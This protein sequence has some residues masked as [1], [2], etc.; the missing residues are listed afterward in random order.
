[1]SINIE[2]EIVDHMV[3]KVWV[4]KLKFSSDDEV[5]LEAT[6][7]ILLV[8]ANNSGKS[9]TI[10][11]IVSKSQGG[12]EY[13]DLVV[14]K[15]LVIEKKGTAQDLESYVKR[16]GQSVDSNFVVGDWQISRY[17]FQHWD[18]PYLKA[19]LC[20]GFIKN[21]DAATRL[22]ICN[23]QQNVGYEEAASKPQHLIYR[24]D[25]LMEKISRLF[26]RAF[27]HGLM[28]NYLGG[29]Q[30]PIHIGNKPEGPE[31]VDR[32]TKAYS[33]EVKKYPALH[34]QGDG[35]RSY[36]GI[37]FEA[38]ASSRDVI[39]IDE[40]EA[41]LHPPQAR[42]LGQTL[43]TEARGQLIVATHD[44]DILRGFL[45]GNKG[46]V[47]I[48]RIRREGNK[49]WVYEAS[50]AS[51]ALLWKT[52]ALRFS[53][54]LDAI[55]HDQAMLCEDDSDCRLI[56]SV[57]DYMQDIHEEAWPDTAYV[58]MGGK[59]GIPTAAEV[60]RAIGVPV[61]AVLDFDA[62][63]D[64]SFFEKI[65]KAFGGD[66]SAAAILWRRVSAA[67]VNGRTPSDAMIKANIQSLL[68]GAGINELPRKQDIDDA[69]KSKSPWADIKRHGIDAVPKGK[70]RQDCE[71]LLEMLEKIGIY[72]IPSG[73]IESFCPTQGGHGPKFVTNVL[74]HVQLDS[75]QL[76]ALREFTEKVHKGC[77]ASIKSVGKSED[78]TSLKNSQAFSCGNTL[79][80]NN[81]ES[82]T[83]F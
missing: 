17:A 61:K 72:L 12:G 34:L 31:F 55:F 14:L 45:E 40:P 41:F 76:R 35:M 65:V 21:L 37:L 19:G 54:A 73:E 79:L 42:K 8:G 10:R 28:I 64:V 33:D 83:H 11:E 39:F 71:L 22:A 70:A 52:P 56:S 9:R 66:W 2:N 74:T 69:Y 81:N 77:A 63:S 16:S 30:I 36:A 6:D 25:V 75:P 59:S 13:S 27:G 49:N 18:Y 67:V 50:P 20:N 46:K 82:A 80:E 62:I 44:S 58:P 47:R 3:P 26:E 29:S 53:R 68:D 15:E 57:A 1:M 43:S 48:L 78:R 38:V 23:L 24:D 4:S 32:A 60:L 5:E 7:K 51:I